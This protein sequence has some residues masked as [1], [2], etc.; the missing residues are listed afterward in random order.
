MAAHKAEQ[1]D[2]C[3]PNVGFGPHVLQALDELRCGVAGRSTGSDELLIALEGVAESKV[4][5]LEVL[6]LV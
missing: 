1:D 2:A 5:D 3:T 4:D 6:L